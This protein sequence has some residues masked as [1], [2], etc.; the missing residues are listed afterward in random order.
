M[1]LGDGYE[2]GKDAEVSVALE[3]LPDMPTPA[4]DALVLERLTVPVADEAIA[5]R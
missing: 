4:I 1:E 5:D 2:A 3:V